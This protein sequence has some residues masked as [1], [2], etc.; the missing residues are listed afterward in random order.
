MLQSLLRGPDQVLIL[1][2]PGNYLDVPSKQWLEEQLAESPK[3][4]LF[5][6][7]DRG[8]LT[9]TAQRI[10]ALKGSDEGNTGETPHPW[11]ANQG[12]WKLGARVVPGHFSQTHDH[13]ELAGRSLQ[14]ILWEDCAVQIHAAVRRCDATS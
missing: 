6:S 12:S 1:D 8:L 3:T 4:I 7:H 5:V 9:R 13:P 2:E 11:P 14:T 10:V